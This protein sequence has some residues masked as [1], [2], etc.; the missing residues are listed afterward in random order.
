MALYIDAHHFASEEICSS[1]SPKMSILD[2]SWSVFF[3]YFDMIS[4]FSVP[5]NTR[6]ADTLELTRAHSIPFKRSGCKLRGTARGAAQLARN[7][8]VFRSPQNL[9]CVT[10]W[11]FCN[12]LAEERK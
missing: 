6:H 4:N 3:K 8:S 1:G 10:F 9:R 7:R 11:S 5:C 2:V 12:L